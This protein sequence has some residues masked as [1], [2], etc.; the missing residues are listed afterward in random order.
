MIRRFFATVLAPLVLVLSSSA[1]SPHAQSPHPAALR[2]LEPVPG[3]TWVR[4]T[5]SGREPLDQWCASVGH[6]VLMTSH[7]GTADVI[8]LLVVTWNV[9]VGGGRVKDFVEKLWA[10]EPDRSHTGLVLLLQETFRAGEEVPDAYPRGLRVPSAIRP[11]PRSL[12]IT[13]IAKQLGM[14]VA[15][16]P[17]MRNGAATNLAERED[18]GNAILSTEPLTDVQAIEVPFGKQRR[19]AVAATVTPRGSG[20]GPLRVISTHFDL[21]GHRVAQAEAIGTRIDGLGGLPLIVGGDFNAM[22]GPNDRSVQAVGRRIPMEPCG[23]GRTHRWP[24]RLD[25][26]AFFVGR[27]DFMFST[28]ES[29]GLTRGCRTL[30][31]TFDSDHLPVLLTVER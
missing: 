7:S 3:V 13:G 1:E 26:L 22:N 5:E 23:T 10:D 12:D 16:V 15:Y 21:G 28:L 25:V 29:S 24:L 30:N 31:D 8:R 2:C 20:I 27:L 4:W 17:S 11:S 6:P 19:V 14:S 9:H 18:R